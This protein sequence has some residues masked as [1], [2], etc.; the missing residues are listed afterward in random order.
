MTKELFISTGREN[1]MFTLWMH[2]SSVGAKDVYYYIQNLGATAKKAQENAEKIA[3]KVGVVLVDNAEGKL[4]PIS[5]GKRKPDNLAIGKYKDMSIQEVYEQDHDYLK[6]YAKE[7]PAPNKHHN[8]F[9]HILDEYMVENALEIAELR[10]EGKDER[11]IYVGK[12]KGKTIDEVPAGYV[13]WLAGVDIDAN[14]SNL[15]ANAIEL[16]NE[17]IDANPSTHVGEI[18]DRITLEVEA[19]SVKSY[20]NEWGGGAVV[21]MKDTEGNEIV[22]MG[23]GD[24][25]VEGEHG[26]IRGTVKDHSMYNGVRQTRLNR[27]HVLEK[28][29]A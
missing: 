5:K 24:H 28:N 3:E 21:T 16:V 29:D 27:V 11:M 20:I 10:D 6:W 22:Y 9:Y 7:K 8:A 14:H 19:V 12:H 25:L 23:S 2:V 4:N 1:K 26:V 15:Q 17:R 18:G 13:E